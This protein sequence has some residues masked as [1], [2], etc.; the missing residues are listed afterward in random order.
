MSVY[1]GAM[2]RFP[3]ACGAASRSSSIMMVMR[4]SCF[5]GPS[6]VPLTA[7]SLAALESSGRSRIVGSA[8]RFTALLNS[9]QATIRCDDGG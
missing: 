2:H 7:T 1:H 4:A 6:A 5:A 9:L 8:Y 3:A